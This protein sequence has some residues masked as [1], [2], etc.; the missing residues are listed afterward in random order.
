MNLLNEISLCYCVSRTYCFG[1]FQSNTE[2]DQFH[3]IE[4]LKVVSELQTPIFCL[5]FLPDQTNTFIFSLWQSENIYISSFD[6]I[7]DRVSQLSSHEI[8]LKA[9]VRTLFDKGLY[10]DSET[11]SVECI[12]CSFDG[13]LVV[14]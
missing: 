5:S 13:N 12:D 1:I 2:S 10:N 3:N 11:G 8:S 6:G 7:V 14:W 9:E 4:G